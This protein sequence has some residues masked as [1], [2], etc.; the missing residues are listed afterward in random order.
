MLFTDDLGFLKHILDEVNFI[1]EL[2]SHA[3]FNDIISDEIKKR[4]LVRSLE[5]IGEASKNI[6]SETR[7][8]Y[9]EVA[10]REISDTRNRMIHEYFILDCELIKEILEHDIPDLKL[11]IDKIIKDLS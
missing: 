1:M 7:K 11:K 9:T 8:K 5:V 6:S 2:N 10:W 3:S 4:A